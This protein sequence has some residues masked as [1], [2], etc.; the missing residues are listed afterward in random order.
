MASAG[1]A[2]LP[3]ALGAALAGPRELS[4]HLTNRLCELRSSVLSC[5]FKV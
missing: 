3:P 4:V 2:A 5:G 1:F